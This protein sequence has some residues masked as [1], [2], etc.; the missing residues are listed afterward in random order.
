MQLQKILLIKK[1]VKA[2]T[3]IRI[4]GGEEEIHIGGIDNPIVKDPLTG[5]PYLPGS[6]LKGCMRSSLEIAKGKTA[7]CSCSSCLICKLFGSA[8]SEKKEH[9]RLIVRDAFLTEQSRKVLREFLPNGIEIKKENTIN[10]VTGVAKSPRTFDRIPRG[11]EFELNIA[12]RIF[13]GDDE[14][15]LLDTLDLALKLVEFNY[16]GGSGSRGYGQV[17]FIDAGIESFDVKT[18]VEKVIKG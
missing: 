3:G 5:E 1:I 4:S 13:E 8:S 10:R 2:K 7:P 18:E 14:K 9:T 15:G 17:E 16:I 11:L 12:L 6:A